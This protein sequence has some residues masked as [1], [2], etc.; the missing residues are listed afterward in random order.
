MNSQNMLDALMNNTNRLIY[1]KDLEGRYTFVNREWLRQSFQDEHNVIGRTDPELFGPEWGDLFRRNDLKVLQT[2]SPLDFEEQVTMPD[3]TV[4]IHHSI[5]FPVY[6][7]QGSLCGTG[8][9][10]SDITERKHLENSL[11]L[12]NQTKDKFFS[13]IAHDLKNPL[14]GLLGLTDLLLDDY[15]LASPVQIEKELR[16][17]NQTTKVLHNL[18]DNLLTWARSQTGL[19]EFRPRSLPLCALVQE[20]VELVQPALQAKNLKLEVDCDKNLRVHADPQM[21]STILRNFL[22]NAIKYS[23]PDNTVHLSVRHGGDQVVVEV[24]DEGIG[25]SAARMDKLF[26]LESK[27][28]TPGTGGELG[29]GLGLL[30][31]KDFAERQQGRVE[32]SSELGKG[33]VMRVLIPHGG[34][35]SELVGVGNLNV[36]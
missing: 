25:I 8:G 21:T 35:G 2:R 24:R 4:I 31:C 29:S 32:V 9:I 17:I 6:D 26:Q 36:A 15:V 22:A 20:C 23:F 19:L 5:K 12:S 14:N 33:T 13:I 16:L 30:L 18:L 11:K 7:N 28:S 27:S 1:F 3:G 34:S 10:S